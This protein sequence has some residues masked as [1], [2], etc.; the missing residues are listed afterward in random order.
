MTF[1]E[2]MGRKVAKYARSSEI[3]QPVQCQFMKQYELPSL[4]KGCRKR[5]N[6]SQ[7]KILPSP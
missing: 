6:N 5:K 4:G 1:G 2:R 3:M 7:N